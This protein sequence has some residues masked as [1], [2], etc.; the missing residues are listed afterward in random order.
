MATHSSV[1]A[2][3]IPG[4]GEPGGLPSMGSHR[5]G[6]DWSDL[7]VAWVDLNILISFLYFGMRNSCNLARDFL[8]RPGFRPLVFRN[9]NSIRSDVKEARKSFTINFDIYI[10]LGIFRYQ[11]CSPLRASLPSPRLLMACAGVCTASPLGELPWARNLRVLIVYLFFLPVML[12][13]VLP[14]LGTDSAEKVSWCLE[15]S[16]F[17]RFPSRD[18]TLSLPLLSLFLSF[19]FFPTS[20]R[21]LGLLFWVPD[22]LCQHS[23]VVLWN[24]LNV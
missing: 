21:R 6:H 23:E 9:N 5:V 11:W 8:Y 24:L 15:T 13:S 10:W 1:H 17:L 16:L 2:W 3:K 14:K 19:I 20:F 22:V 12:P 4:T 7:A 18:G